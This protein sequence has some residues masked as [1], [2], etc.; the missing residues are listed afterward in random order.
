ML[1]AS[2]YST[3]SS[4]SQLGWACRTRLYSQRSAH[5]K[6]LLQA[7]HGHLPMSLLWGTETW[8]QA[9][10]QGGIPAVP[11][12]LVANVGHAPWGQGGWIGLSLSLDVLTELRSNP[13][14]FQNSGQIPRTPV[15]SVWFGLP[16]LWFPK[17]PGFPLLA[18]LVPR[19]TI[20]PGPSTHARPRP[21][22]CSALRSPM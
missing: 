5:R 19:S 1:I 2:P 7:D 6:A 9:E 11:R 21:G 3:Y 20:T 15:G 12:A 17:V 10:T 18:T 4:H 13:L 22:Q 16:L 14:F 8:W